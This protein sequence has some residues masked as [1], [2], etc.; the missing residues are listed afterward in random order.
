MHTVIIDLSACLS[1]CVSLCLSVCLVGSGGV[2]FGGGGGGVFVCCCFLL[3]WG[4]YELVIHR[5]EFSAYA[6]AATGVSSNA[7]ACVWQID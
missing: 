4:V 6:L 7:V 5:L 3:F 2:L 1:I